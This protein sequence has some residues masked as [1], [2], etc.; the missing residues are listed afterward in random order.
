MKLQIK[1][2]KTL[3]ELNKHEQ[4]QQKGVLL[5]GAPVREQILQGCK[6]TIQG[7]GI[8][9]HLVIVTANGYDNAS[10][11]YIRNKIK[12]CEEVGIEVRVVQIGFA[13]RTKASFLNEL[14]GVIDL[15]NN[16]ESVDGYFIQCPLPFNISIN[17]F[18]DRINPQKDVDGFTFANLGRSFSNQ[19]DDALISCTPQAIVDLLHYYKIN[20]SGKDIVIVNRSNIVGIPL[21]PLLINQDATVTICHSKTKN[22]K[23]KCR[24]ADIV[25]T[26]IGKA[27]F[28][29]ATWFKRGAYVIDVSINRDHDGALC[30]DV[31]KSDYNKLNITPVP[32][33]IGVI[34]TANVIKNTL[35]AC[36]INRRYKI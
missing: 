8:T 20:T 7:Y 11:V 6:A 30:G 24:N 26:A 21:I 32:K 36:L 34:T 25:I 15:L 9:P 23:N 33:G 27:N 31:K 19:V 14:W 10:S 3:S 1:E 22:L 16:D 4:S 2:S 18:S 29:N 5:F 13:N 17:D 12:T 35:I 28:M